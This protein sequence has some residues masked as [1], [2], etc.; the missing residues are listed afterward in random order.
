MHPPLDLAALPHCVE[1]NPINPAWQ[2]MHLYRRLDV[3]RKAIERWG[4]WERMAAEH[5]RRITRY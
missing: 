5:R 1:P 3:R 2:L 4:S